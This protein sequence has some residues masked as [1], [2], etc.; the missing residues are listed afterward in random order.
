MRIPIVPKFTK[1]SLAAVLIALFASLIV[2]T[3]TATA[4]PLDYGG[5]CTLYPDNRAATVDSLRF[6]CNWGQQDRIYAD[7][8]AGAVPMGPKNGWVVRPPAMP[9]IASGI[10]MGKTFQTGPDG[11]ILMNQ[12]TGARV[13]AFRADVYRG[14]S[15][16]DGKTAWAINYGPSVLPIYD[17]IREVS[18][19]VWL[20]FSWWHGMFQSPQL[21]AF[22]LS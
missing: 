16:I 14:P 22:V 1:L 8:A 17:E 15:W 7:A 10:W 19:G 13:E 3:G 4:A 5:G 21:L 12:I 11:G 9:E 6:R 18:P 2:G 20:G